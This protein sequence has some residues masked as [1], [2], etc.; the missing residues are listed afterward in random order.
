MARKIIFG[1]EM[2]WGIPASYW[3]GLSSTYFSGERLRQ[4][5]P[6]Y[7]FYFITHWLYQGWPISTHRRTT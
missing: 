4:P 5:L 7:R 1:N 6:S 3:G 2:R